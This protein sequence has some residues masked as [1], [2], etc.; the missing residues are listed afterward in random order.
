VDGDLIF[1]LNYSTI[2][3]EIELF[4]DAEGNPSDPGSAA[5]DGTSTHVARRDHVHKGPKNAVAIYPTHALNNTVALSSTEYLCPFIDG[6]FT[7]ERAMVITRPGIVKNFF[8]RQTGNQPA[9]GSLV[10][11]V[12]KNT[13]TDEITIT[14]PAGTA[15]SQ[16]HSDT[17]DSFTVAAG[18]FI[19][20]KFVNNASAVSTTIGFVAVEV[21]Y[22]P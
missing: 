5:S 17:S 22:D 11:H 13:A 18:D 21:I 6:D 15:G 8:V 4:D 3:S 20:F 16:T 7:A 2:R 12:R 10:C 14:I 1:A 9:S 19:G